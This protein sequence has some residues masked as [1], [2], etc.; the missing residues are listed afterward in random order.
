MCQYFVNISSIFEQY[1]DNTDNSDN[2]GHYNHD[3]KF[4]YHYI[5][6]WDY[7]RL[8]DFLKIFFFLTFQIIYM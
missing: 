4:S 6:N 8:I 3:N 7:E 1:R 2:F 5:S